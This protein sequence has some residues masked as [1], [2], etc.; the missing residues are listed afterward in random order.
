MRISRAVTMLQSVDRNF[1]TDSLRTKR[2]YFEQEKEQSHSSLNILDSPRNLSE[3][4]GVN[5]ATLTASTREIPISRIDVRVKSYILN[6]AAPQKVPRSSNHTGPIKPLPNMQKLPT[7]EHKS[8][9]AEVDQSYLQAQDTVFLVKSLREARQGHAHQVIKSKYKLMRS[10]RVTK[11]WDQAADSH[12]PLGDLKLIVR[13][14]I[15]DEPGI[16]SYVPLRQISS[17]RLDIKRSDRAFKPASKLPADKLY[18]IRHHSSYNRLEVPNSGTRSV[19]GHGKSARAE[20][21]WIWRGRR[22]STVGIEVGTPGKKAE[23]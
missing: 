3:S 21:N 16:R 13:E 10:A 12:P 11:S 20:R 14:A 5:T 19:E 7:N 23:A 1:D 8:I 15:Q 2:E 4:R 6:T 22:G 17:G 18:S 9:A